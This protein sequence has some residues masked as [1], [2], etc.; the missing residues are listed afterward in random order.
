MGCA[1][2]A[3]AK[4]KGNMGDPEV[5]HIGG[6]GRAEILCVENTVIAS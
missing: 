3:K 2:I 6:W 1:V 5:S 4:Q